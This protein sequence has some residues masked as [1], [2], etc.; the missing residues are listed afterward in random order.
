M[1]SPSAVAKFYEDV[2]AEFT[3]RKRQGKVILAGIGMRDLERI[4]C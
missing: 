4:R 3:K 1:K 2:Q